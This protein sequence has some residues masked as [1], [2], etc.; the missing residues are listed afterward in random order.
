MTFEIL[1]AL[2]CGSLQISAEKQFM[3]PQYAYSPAPKA[4]A[5]FAPDVSVIIL[6]LKDTM[7]AM[8]AQR[9]WY[10][11]GRFAWGMAR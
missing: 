11:H 4:M 1:S 9:S 5:G 6:T 2:D 3:M 7:R 8:T 10:S